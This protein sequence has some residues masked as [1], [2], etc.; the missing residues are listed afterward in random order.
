[1]KKKI[2]VIL[3]GRN[4]GSTNM[5]CDEFINGAKE[6]GN[7]VEKI[8]INDKNI[9]YCLGCRVCREN[10]G[11]CIHK[12]DMQEILDKII[13]SDVIVFASPVYFYS[14][15]AQMKTVMDRSYAKT[16][17]IKDKEVYIITTG[18]APTKE[19]MSIIVE[20]FEKYIECFENIK[21][22]EIIYGCG[23]IERTS[24]KEKEVIKEAYD[25]G[26]SIL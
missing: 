25:M 24:L 15:N 6:A 14:F 11:I 4:E 20:S 22:K 10:K 26:K 1:M 5:L 23:A 13:N 17:I 9:N 16:N 18:A 3:S 12:D 21:L 19:Y 7:Y 2:F 8:L